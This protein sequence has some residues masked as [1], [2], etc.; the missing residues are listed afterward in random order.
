M[1]LFIVFILYCLGG[2]YYFYSEERVIEDGLIEDMHN[3]R[4]ALID[5]T[6]YLAEFLSDLHYR[7]S[8]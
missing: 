1:G 8:Y 4:Q 5:S 2:A 3:D 6:N 7:H